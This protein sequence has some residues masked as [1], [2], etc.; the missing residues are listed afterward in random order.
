ME[1]YWLLLM[2]Y[3]AHTIAD[4]HLQGNLANLK[5]KS[6]WENHPDYKPEYCKDYQTALVIHGVEWSFI[7]HIPMIWVYGFNPTVCLL[8]I[9]NAGLHA[10]IDDAKCN[11]K[12]INLKLDQEFHFIQ[13]VYSVIVMVTIYGA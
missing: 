8:I 10:V 4:F 13:I 3:V 5:Q 9:I 1:W 2:M 6:W 11:K 7:T 12:A